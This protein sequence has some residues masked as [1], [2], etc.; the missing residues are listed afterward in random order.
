VS[1]GNGFLGIYMRDQLALG[2]AW[3]ELAG[4]AARRNRGTA[5]GEALDE[6]HRG[7]AEDVETFEGI[8]RVLGFAGSASK[9]LLAVLGERAARFK[10]NGRIVAYSPLSR[11]EE[12]D[13]LM[14]GIDGKVTLWTTLRE[15]ANLERRFP[16][17]D[18]GAL[19]D[20]ARAQRATLEPHHREAA[21]DALAV[22][23]S[24]SRIQVQGER[25]DAASINDPDALIDEASEASFPASDPPGFWAQDHLPSRQEP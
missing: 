4:R 5:V 3:R 25:V 18:F 12:L 7:I 20:R 21:R 14:M 16:G 1:D 17:V 22:A 15:G 11:F 6:V 24:L 19:I 23:A 10:P 9:N 8:M 13:A 2:I